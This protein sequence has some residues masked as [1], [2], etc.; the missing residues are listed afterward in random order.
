MA[1]VPDNKVS[2]GCGTLIL[3]ALIVMIFS[4]GSDSHGLL[5]EVQGLRNEVRQLAARPDTV[6][7]IQA[8]RQSIEAL[9][10]SMDHQGKEI[11]ALKE[12]VKRLA[13]APQS[14]PPIE[15]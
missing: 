2:L 1:Q 15:R 7:E 6:Q 10:H 11:V 4:R 8:L 12:E 3:I 5:R 9:Q 14:I 13:A